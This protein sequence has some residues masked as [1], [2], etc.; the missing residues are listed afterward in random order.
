[1][2]LSRLVHEENAAFR[3]EI[4]IESLFERLYVTSK[5]ANKRIMAQAGAFIIVGLRDGDK[6]APSNLRI[7]HFTIP[8]RAKAKVLKQLDELGING[9]TM[10]P[11]LD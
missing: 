2:E 6:R 10:F 5:Q 3:N 7:S 1:M 8:K 4:K 11:E 9:R